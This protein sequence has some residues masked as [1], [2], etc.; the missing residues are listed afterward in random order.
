MVEDFSYLSID[1]NTDRVNAKEGKDFQCLEAFPWW[2]FP[3]LQRRWHDHQD[4]YCFKASHETNQNKITVVTN[5]SFNSN[6]PPHYCRKSKYNHKLQMT[7]NE[8]KVDSTSQKIPREVGIKGTISD[9][10]DMRM[11]NNKMLET[12]NRSFNICEKR[13]SQVKDT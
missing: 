2:M 7:K 6:S 8:F 1:W 4:M 10:S 3:G 13:N 11:W 5:C 12:F 9:Y